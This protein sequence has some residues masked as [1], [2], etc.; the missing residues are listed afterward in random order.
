MLI[1]R[2]TG[3]R[4]IRFDSL[5]FVDQSF[6]SREPL[7]SGSTRLDFGRERAGARSDKRE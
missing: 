4:S 7:E 6:E 1:G 2:C 5:T 3:S